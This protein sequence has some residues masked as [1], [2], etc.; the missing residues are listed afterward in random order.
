M[1]SKDFPA[2]PPGGVVTAAGG[3]CADGEE[4]VGCLIVDEVHSAKADALKA[5]L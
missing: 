1:I 5:M 3:P 2:F 4:D